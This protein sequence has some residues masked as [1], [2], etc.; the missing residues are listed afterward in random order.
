MVRVYLNKDVIVIPKYLFFFKLMFFVCLY[1][2][3]SVALTHP[4]DHQMYLQPNA[5]RLLNKQSTPNQPNMN[6]FLENTNKNLTIF[7]FLQKKCGYLL[8]FASVLF[9]RVKRNPEISSD[10]IDTHIFFFDFVVQIFRSI[11][12]LLVLRDQNNF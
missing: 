10:A 4:I 12:S 11:G 3:S 9:V 2:F 1:A 8:N 5:G 6:V 7:H